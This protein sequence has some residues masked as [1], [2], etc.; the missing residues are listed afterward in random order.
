MV[1]HN[2]FFSK[3]IIGQFIDKDSVGFKIIIGF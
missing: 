3:P 2:L 1:Y